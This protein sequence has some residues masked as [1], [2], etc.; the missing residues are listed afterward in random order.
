MVVLVVLSHAAVALLW[1]VWA[2]PPDLLWVA[3]LGDC[4]AVPGGMTGASRLAGTGWAVVAVAEKRVVL[5]PLAAAAS[6][7]A[8]AAAPS[9]AEAVAVKGL[10]A[11]VE[12][13]W[14]M[15]AAAWMAAAAAALLEAAAVGG[16]SGALLSLVGAMAHVALAVGISRT[17]RSGGSWPVAGTAAS[18]LLSWRGKL[19]GFL[20]LTAGSSSGQMAACVCGLHG[21]P[22]LG[23]A[24]WMSVW[25]DPHLGGGKRLS[26]FRTRH[27]A[28]GLWKKSDVPENSHRAARGPR[29]EAHHNH[30]RCV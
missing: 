22:A 4:L 18:A 6:W 2:Y 3:L 11:V 28:D 24:A 20:C 9:E 12:A 21:G 23:C 26:A 15:A 5:E 19:A 8:A 1:W 10:L 16:A 7:L 27:G 25:A 13:A 17:L 29:Q 30:E 14:L